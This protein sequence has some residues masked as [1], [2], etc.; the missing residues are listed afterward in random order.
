LTV[1]DADTVASSPP[2]AEAEVAEPEA[3]KPLLCVYYLHGSSRAEANAR[4]LAA[5]VGPNL[6]G[7]EFKAETDLPDDAVIK[8]SEER[9]HAVARMIGKSLGDSGYRWKIEK[10]RALIQSDRNIIEV[11]LPMKK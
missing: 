2:R 5:R 6:I 4:S 1:P 8:F 10:A 9:N 7:S 11:W 3:A